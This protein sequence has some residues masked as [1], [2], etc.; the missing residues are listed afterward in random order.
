MNLDSFSFAS[1][2]GREYAV[3]RLVASAEEVMEREGIAS[4]TLLMTEDGYGIGSRDLENLK[5]ANRP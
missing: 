4:A 5:Y 1:N 2:E 3:S